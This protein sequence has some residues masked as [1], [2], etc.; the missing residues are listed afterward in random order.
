[1]EEEEQGIASIA[2]QGPRALGS[3]AVTVSASMLDTEDIVIGKQQWEAI[4]ARRRGGQ[5]ISGIGRKLELDRKTPLG[6]ACA[7][8]L[9][10]PTDVRHRGPR[11][12]T[13]TG[14]GLRS[15]RQR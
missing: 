9:G 5:S 10:N 13:R 1:M 6:H 11:C 3:D 14:S 7:S 15:A 4:H 8:S 12:S 2:A